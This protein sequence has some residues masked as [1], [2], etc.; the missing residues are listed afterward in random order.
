MPQPEG[1]VHAG[2]VGLAAVPPHHLTHRVG[3]VGSGLHQ[4]EGDMPGPHGSPCSSSSNCTRNVVRPCTNSL[5]KKLLLLLLPVQ[6]LPPNLSAGTS[7]ALI[8]PH[9]TF[10]SCC[11][12]STQSSPP[13]QLSCCWAHRH[14]AQVHCCGEGPAG[15]Q[16]CKV[17]VQRLREVGAV[18][19]GRSRGEWF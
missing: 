5:L 9:P 2:H 13:A 19:A 8:G 4:P 15:H 14:T 16:A 18:P 12:C 1:Q 7:K 17:A 11:C 6:V 10:R 3:G